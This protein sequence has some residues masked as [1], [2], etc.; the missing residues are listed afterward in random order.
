MKQLKE[1]IKILAE[2]PDCLGELRDTIIPLEQIEALKKIPRLVMGEIR[3]VG[4][5]VSVYDAIDKSSVDAFLPTICYTGTEY[6]EWKTLFS[7]LNTFKKEIEKTL[8]IYC[9]DPVLVGSPVFWWALNGRFIFEL[10]NRF[11]FYSPCLGCRLYSYAVRIPLC[12][13]L[14]CRMIIGA[15]TP[16]NG[17][18]T[19]INESHQV[20]YYCKALLSN[21][22]INLMYNEL[23][24]KTPSDIEP[25]VYYKATGTSDTCCRCILREN[26]LRLNKVQEKELPD[27]KNYFEQFAIPAAA[28]IISR[29]LAGKTA[30]YL[31]EAMNTLLPGE[32][33]KSK[34]IYN[35]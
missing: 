11:K 24:K 10:L 22:G 3:G 31:H 27:N 25:K 35:K 33:I 6:G 5:L 23:D 18:F 26:Y 28:K 34:K 14:N 30:D 9:L 29:A 13:Q 32:N 12:K 21:F 17:S 4:S 1:Y 2:K 15:I 8:Q 19:A 16:C 7:Q 20:M